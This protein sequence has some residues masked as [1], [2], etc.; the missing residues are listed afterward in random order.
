MHVPLPEGWPRPQGY[1]T[2]VTVKGRLAYIPGRMAQPS[3][4]DVAT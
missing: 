1:P 4:D 3:Q 2:G